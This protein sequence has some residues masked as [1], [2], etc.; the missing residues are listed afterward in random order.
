[1]TDPPAWAPLQAAR[2][3]LGEFRAIA[4]DHNH[5]RDLTS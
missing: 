5:Y 3:R 2:T 1:M 4:E